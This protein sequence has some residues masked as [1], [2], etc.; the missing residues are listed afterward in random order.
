MAVN[1]LNLDLNFS[2]NNVKILLKV[3]TI[4]LGPATNT[5]TDKRSDVQTVQRLRYFLQLLL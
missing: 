1:E 3:K 4:I 2:S 5:K